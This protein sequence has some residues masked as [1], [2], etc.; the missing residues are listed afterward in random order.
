MLKVSTAPHMFA[1]QDTNA[2]MKDVVIA[3]LPAAC[4]GIF[5]FGLTALITIITSIASCVMWE[6]LTVRYL[7]KKPST[8]NDYSAIITGLLLA[9]N[10]PATIPVWMILI[11]SFMAIVVGKM[12][13]GGLGKNV[14][15]PALVGRV[16]LFISFPVQMTMWMKPNWHDFF[17]RDIQTGATTLGILKHIDASSSATSLTYGN[18][19]ISQIP[20]YWH[21]FIGYTGG[22]IGEVSALA[23]IL[24]GIYLLIKKVITW[25]IPFYYLGSVF[26]FSSLMWLATQDIKFD[27][28]T[29]LLSGGLILGAIFMATDYTTT[30]MTTK[31]KIIFA[32]GCGILTVIIRFYGAYPEGV[33]F[34]IL[35]MNAFSPLI[36]KFYYTRVY[37]TRKK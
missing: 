10:L 27:P 14:F 9:F 23:L 24:G 31:G 28:I 32:L 7:L 6:Y 36:D 30:P 17:N 18:P 8:I 2:I 25:H 20:D 5:N 16:F 19:D 11:G 29:H 21:M 4:V 33:S 37:G 22:C 26:L 15:N 35:I 1:K 12:A 3:L 13:F 34:A